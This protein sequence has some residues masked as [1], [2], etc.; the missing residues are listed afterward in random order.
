MA[1]SLTLVGTSQG[2]CVPNQGGWVGGCVWGGGGSPYHRGT[3]MCVRVCGW[4]AGCQYM[5]VVRLLVGAPHAPWS[6]CDVLLAPQ[7][8][9]PHTRAVYGPHRAMCGPSPSSL[10]E[11]SEI[12]GACAPF[13]GVA[14]Q[15][16]KW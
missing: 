3:C 9:I 10:C 11:L 2:G 12:S 4:V 14:K 1:G 7:L 8:H 5:V 6:N 15:F 16:A 13:E